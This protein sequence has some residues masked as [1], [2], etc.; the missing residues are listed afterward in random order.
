VVD[1]ASP[2]IFDDKGVRITSAIGL[3]W[4]YDERNDPVEP[5]S[6]YLL[7]A[8]QDLAGLG[9]DSFYSRSVGKAKGW[10]SFYDDEVVASLEVEAGA[11]V[12]FGDELRVTDRFY[13]GGDKFRGFDSA[14]IGPRD[15]S[16][17]TSGGTSLGRDDA[18]GGNYF[19]VI[20]S[21]VT[22]PLG[23]PDELG[24]YGGLF[25]DAGTVWSLDKTS[26]VDTQSDN[27]PT[28]NIDDSLQL[29][30]SIGASLFIDSPFGPLR[31]N[32]AYP[33]LSE[34]YD[35]KEYFRFTAGT[36]F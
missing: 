12:G 15:I 17:F 35:S 21:N 30:A 18:L 29:R 13:L 24:I 10:T 27:N 8:N 33:L 4:T 14:G 22:F 36:R 16:T 32:F 19:A 34:S 28:I 2:V 26:Y 3:T 20:R 23:L 11:L 5:T 25:A 6:G 1:R 9:G 7:T 31:F